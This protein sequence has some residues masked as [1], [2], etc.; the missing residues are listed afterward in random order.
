VKLV[1]G[2]HEYELESIKVVSFPKDCAIAIELSGDTWTWTQE[3]MARMAD[4]L[5]K[6]KCFE[7]HDIFCLRNGIK[8][9]AYLEDSK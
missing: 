9:S 3:E 5:Q 6:V 1:D 2:D 8:I 7:G 4:D